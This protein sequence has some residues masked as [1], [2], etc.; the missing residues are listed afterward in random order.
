MKIR[1]SIRFLRRIKAI[2]TAYNS[3]QLLFKLM[4]NLLQWSRSQRGLMPFKKVKIDLRSII[5]EQVDLY[6]TI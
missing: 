1:K 2:N 5:D 4:Q 3:A 6:N